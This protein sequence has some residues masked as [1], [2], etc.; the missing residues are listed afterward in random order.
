VPVVLAIVV[1][2]QERKRREAARLELQ[3]TAR[4]PAEAP[5]G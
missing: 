1:V 4:R 3:A 5:G 2:W